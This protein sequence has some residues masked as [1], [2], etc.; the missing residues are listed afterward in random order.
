ML[1]GTYTRMLRV[2]HK[3][4]WRDNVPNKTLSGDL[5]PISNVIRKRKLKFA[6]HTFRD[7]SSTA[8]SL[9]TWDPQHGVSSRGRP[10]ATFVDTLLRDT[11]MEN[12]TQLEK[13]MENRA[14]WRHL[15]SRCC[16]NGNDPK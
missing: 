16:V 11:G 4:S 5:Q 6:G 12:A 14:E 13:L 3:V 1:D 7:K 9:V 10:N 15:T 2:V 8:H